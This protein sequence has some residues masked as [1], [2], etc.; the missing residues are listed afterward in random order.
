[1]IVPFFLANS[2]QSKVRSQ[3]GFAVWGVPPVRARNSADTT[4]LL[5]IPKIEDLMRGSL[6]KAEAQ[7]DNLNYPRNFTR[8][9][10][11]YTDET[12]AGLIYPKERRVPG[13]LTATMPSKDAS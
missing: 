1:M 9:D 11:P 3:S 6:S 2:C 5:A 4:S 10:W 8:L 13:N 7:R 12:R